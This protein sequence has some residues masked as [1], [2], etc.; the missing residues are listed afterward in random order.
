VVRF[1]PSRWSE[2]PA[3]KV[4]CDRARA[5]SLGFERCYQ[6]DMNLKGG[7]PVKAEMQHNILLIHP[8]DGR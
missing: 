1:A 5:H 2:T 8:T 4:T 7:D 3:A 6:I